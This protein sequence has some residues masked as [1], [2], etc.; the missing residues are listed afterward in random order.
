[1][2]NLEAR[3]FKSSKNLQKRQ[4]LELEEW[5]FPPPPTLATGLKTTLCLVSFWMT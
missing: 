3:D 5:H 1:M 2:A 4:N